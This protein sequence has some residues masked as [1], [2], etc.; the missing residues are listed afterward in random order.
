MM[1]AP[2]L[3]LGKITSKLLIKKSKKSGSIKQAI[4]AGT[5]VSVKD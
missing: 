3:K 4:G 2:T 5:P 1:T